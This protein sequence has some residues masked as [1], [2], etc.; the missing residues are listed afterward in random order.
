[1][2]SDRLSGSA[3]KAFGKVESAVGD[4]A[5]DADT[6][7]TGFVRQAQ[8]AAQNAF[9]QAKDQMR[10]AVRG[11]SDSASKI[12]GN[13]IDSGRSI[14]VDG[15]EAFSQGIQNRPGSALLAA[16]IVGFALGIIIAKGSQPPRPRRV[17]DRY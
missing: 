13:A 3:K 7:A 5:G 8:G 11:L 4:A 9:G 16:G 17:W 1:M 2:D 6:Q 15:T 10:D 14:A 12:A